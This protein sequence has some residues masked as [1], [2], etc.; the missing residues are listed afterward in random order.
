MATWDILRHNE[1]QVVDRQVAS[2]QDPLLTFLQQGQILALPSGPEVIC[3]SVD[4][5]FERL[6]VARTFLDAAEGGD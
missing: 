3:G 5:L 6:P 4:P 1:D 2:F